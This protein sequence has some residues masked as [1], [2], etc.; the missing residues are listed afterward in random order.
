MQET[1]R[2]IDSRR[3]LEALRSGVPNKDAVL[4]LGCDQ[5]DVERRFL[6]QLNALD[7][8]NGEPRHVPGL[9]VAGGF[10]T[11]KSHLLEYL[12]NMAVSSG[13]VCSRVVISKETPLFDAAKVFRAAIEAAIVPGRSG[14][15]IHEVA[16]GLNQKTPGYAD[17]FRWANS[18][19]SGIG[20]L[21]PATL[22]LHERLSQDPELVEQICNFWA[23]DKLPIGGVKAGLRQIG[24]AASYSVKPIK[25]KELARQRFLFAA[26]LFR[27]A[28]FKGWTVLIDEVELIGRY[29]LLQRGRSYAELATWLG[30]IESE[31]YPGLTAVAAIT[32]DFDLGV[33]QGKGDRDYVGPRLRAKETDEYT[34]L[35]ARAEV[36]IR[37]IERESVLLHR[38]DDT[39]RAAIRERLQHIHATAYDWA[40]PGLPSHESKGGRPMRSYVRRWINE[41]DL[42][43]LYPGHVVNTEE[44]ELKT[45]Y[46]ENPQLEEP[47]EPEV[48]Q[49]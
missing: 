34:M 8:A 33:L 44:E 5:P 15:A 11:G 39:A 25:V 24:Q 6:E 28:G 13:F 38:P 43:R 40:P 37:V 3:A 36:G 10:G 9:L 46:E 12:E 19:E 27:A 41:W 22:M 45:T 4:A 16:L 42:N 20:S 2:P 30:R 48:G 26:R 17:L 23:G 14:Q 35:A 31:G 1:T 29:S 18:P 21:F 47:P 32:D 7:A 49:D